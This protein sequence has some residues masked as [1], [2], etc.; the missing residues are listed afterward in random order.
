MRNLS[1]AGL[2]LGIRYWD[3]DLELHPTTLPSVER[4]Q[5]WVDGF[6]GA[7]F[8]REVS[9][10]WNWTTRL[11]VGAGGTDFTFGFSTMFGRELGTGS[12][13]M[14]GLKLL[15]VDYEEPAA[16]GIPFVLDTMFFGATICYMFD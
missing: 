14:L 13:F 6:V 5:D 4:G 8:T 11:N 1:Q 16:N 7:R 2:E 3:L 15:D 12:R 10:A 9:D